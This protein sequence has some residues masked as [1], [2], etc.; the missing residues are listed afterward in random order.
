MVQAEE[1]YIQNAGEWA[2]KTERQR[3]QKQRK[4]E[5]QKGEWDKTVEPRDMI[6]RF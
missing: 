4:A 6:L 2:G 1:S 3:K 5:K